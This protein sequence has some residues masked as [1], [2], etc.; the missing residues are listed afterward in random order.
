[1][2]EGKIRKLPF[3][4][5]S[6]HTEPVCHSAQSFIPSALLSFRTP[7]CHSA[8]PLVIPHTLLSFRACRGIP[9]LF[10][11]LQLRD[12]STSLNMTVYSLIPSTPSCH[13]EPVEESL[14]PSARLSFCTPSCHSEPAEE[15][16]SSSRGPFSFFFLSS[17]MR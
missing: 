11:S 9:L 14:L 2:K 7:S 16:L 15:S 12:V 6:C 1:M 4:T 13:S 5:L 17:F 3:R 10:V 8:H